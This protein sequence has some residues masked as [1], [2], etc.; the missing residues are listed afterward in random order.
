MW[1]TYLVGSGLCAWLA[2][3][4]LLCHS[5]D[6]MIAFIGMIWLLSSARVAYKED[7]DSSRG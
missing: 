4:L 3:Y 5:S 1:W 7:R 2:V 6:W